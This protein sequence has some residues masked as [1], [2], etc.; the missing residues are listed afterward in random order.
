MKKFINVIFAS[1]LLFVFTGVSFADNYFVPNIPG[2]KLTSEGSTSSFKFEKRQYD[3]GY[4]AYLYVKNKSTSKVFGKKSMKIL[5]TM[6]DVKDLFYTL[7]AIRNKELYFDAN[8]V[9]PDDVR[10][11]AHESMQEMGYVNRFI[12]TEDYATL[13]VLPII[14]NGVPI[15]IF[16]FVADGTN[17]RGVKDVDEFWIVDEKKLDSIIKDLGRIREQIYKKYKYK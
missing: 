13:Y 6:V 11:L 3:D 16:R 5:F 10:M 15:I 9:N 14:K 17:A 12:I 7:I 4:S 8:G 1:V 2:K